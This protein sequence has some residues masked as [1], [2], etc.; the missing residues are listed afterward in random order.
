MTKSSF[1]SLFILILIYSCF[2]E[3]GKALSGDI[4]VHDPS[5]II[6][7]GNKYWTFSTGDGINAIY[8][9]D[10]FSWTRGK[11]VFESGKWPAWINR[12]VASFGGGFWAPDITFLNG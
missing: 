1:Y 5:T 8:S 3:E 2:P 6:K 12:Y 9:T 10:L 4:V 11:P 7:E